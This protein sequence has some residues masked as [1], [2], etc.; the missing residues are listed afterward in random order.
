M[1][2]RRCAK[3]QACSSVT[4]SPASSASRSSR[5][6]S[7]RS[8]PRAR[9]ASIAAGWPQ[10]LARGMR[11]AGVL[12][13]ESD[14]EAFQPR[15]RRRSASRIAVSGYPDAAEFH[16]LHHAADAEDRR[17]LRSVA[18][19]DRRAAHPCARRG[20]EARIPRPR[21]L[22]HRSALRRG[23]AR[24]SA[25]RCICRRVRGRDRHDARQPSCAGETETAVGDTT[26]FCVVD[27]EGNAVS[28]IQSLNSGFGSGVT[29]GDTGVLL[30]NRMA[31][32]HLAQATPTG[33]RRASAY[34]TR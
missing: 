24:S 34:A 22:R 7:R 6:R 14:L 33:S 15:C 28:G 13:D 20:E 4:S 10:R 31:Y 1:P 18:A 11:E 23:A 19:L 25:V 8:R 12:V 29:A 5:A 2:C 26:Y 16:R 9:K 3:P 21:A 17:A 30:N 27:A 32:W